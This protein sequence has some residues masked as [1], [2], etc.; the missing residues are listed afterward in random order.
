MTENIFTFALVIL[1]GIIQG[2]L[3]ILVSVLSIMYF[4]RIKK[5][6]W[7]KNKS[8]TIRYI[9]LSILTFLDAYFLYSVV[10]IDPEVMFLYIFWSLPV[11]LSMIY[12][13]KVIFKNGKYGEK[14]L[15]ILVIITP[16]AMFY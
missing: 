12:I 5:E 11:S 8:I 13:S 1:F 14:L 2:L 9:L 10:F 4:H 16:D 15:A 7:Y 3:P 6:N